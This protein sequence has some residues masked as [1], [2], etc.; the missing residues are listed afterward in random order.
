MQG[1]AICKMSLGLCNAKVLKNTG[2]LPRPSR[3]PC[4][5][6][7]GLH[8]ACHP[9]G[10]RPCLGIA[11]LPAYGATVCH[12]DS[13]TPPR[14]LHR[15]STPRARSA[16]QTVWYKLYTAANTTGPHEQ[17]GLDTQPMCGIMQSTPPTWMSGACSPLR[18]LVYC[19][20]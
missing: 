2:R 11:N 17:S 10:H 8:A 13:P 9:P 14:Q 20:L 6:W 18:R 3:R 15:E 1:E 5:G 7:P 12:S 19:R 4:R 16:P